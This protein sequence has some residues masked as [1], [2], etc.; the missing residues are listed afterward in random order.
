MLMSNF[1]TNVPIIPRDVLI[2]IFSYMNSSSLFAM[3]YVS[4][5]YHSI[6]KC[7][8]DRRTIIIDVIF[9]KY[10]K[11][12][13][14]FT[15]GKFDMK[16]YNIYQRKAAKSCSFEILKYIHAN[17]PSYT[18]NAS[19]LSDV[20]ARIEDSEQFEILKWARANG[21][22]LRTLTCSCAALNGHLEI[23]KWARENECPWNTW[24]CIHT[25]RTSIFSSPFQN[26]KM[27]IFSSICTC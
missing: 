25:P 22:P 14:W 7:D 12:F 13:K 3:T 18:L 8:H 11:L 23:L 19:L 2:L 6:I 15:N 4:I 10:T 17:N 24:T 5:F 27:S 9:N 16:Y 21:C 20:I 1:V 26:L